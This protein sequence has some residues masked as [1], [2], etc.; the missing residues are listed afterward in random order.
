MAQTNNFDNYIKIN[1]KIIDKCFSPEL[2]VVASQIQDKNK[3]NN[4]TLNFIDKDTLS[5]N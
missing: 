1:F 4:K 5:V 2:R 3:C